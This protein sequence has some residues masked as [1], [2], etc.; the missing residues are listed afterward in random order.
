MKDKKGKKSDDYFVIASNVP[1]VKS[2]LE[3]DLHNLKLRL[4]IQKEWVAKTEYEISV[5]EE[6]IGNE[7]KQE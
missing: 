3:Y 2:G 4:R 7:Q 5:L 1:N 6:M